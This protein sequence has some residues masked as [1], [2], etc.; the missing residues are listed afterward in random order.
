M[1]WAFSDEEGRGGGGQR[2]DDRMLFLEAGGWCDVGVYVC[3]RG[4]HFCVIL[5]LPACLSACLSVWCV[6]LSS[7]C[8]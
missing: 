1:G 6:R 3:V 5:N 2:E 7:L 4:Y 8:E